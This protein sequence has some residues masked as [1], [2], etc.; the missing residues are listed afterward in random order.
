MGFNLRITPLASSVAG[1]VIAG[2]QA[3]DAGDFMR[4]VVENYTG[5]VIA[6][7][8]WDLARFMRG[9]GVALIGNGVA[10]GARQFGFQGNIIRTKRLKLS[11][12]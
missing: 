5:W 12:F 2:T 10:W 9:A 1:L 6:E 11:V 4:R 7:S 8:K 3:A